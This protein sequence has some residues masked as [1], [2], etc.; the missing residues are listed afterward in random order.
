MK[1]FKDHLNSLNETE[2]TPGRFYIVKGGISKRPFN[3]SE[4][5]Y[6]KKEMAINFAGRTDDVVRVS[7]TM[8]SI[9]FQK[10]FFKR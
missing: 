6:K 7:T 2:Y 5:E 8:D 10:V 4:D 1:K 3:I 9:T